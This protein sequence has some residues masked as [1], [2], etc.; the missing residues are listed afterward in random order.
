MDLHLAGRSALV[1]GASKGIGLAIT[2]ALAAEG[3]SVTA[4]ALK[5]SPELDEL[6]T[7]ADVTSVRV[8]LTHPA[9]PDEL[10]AAAAAERGGIDILVNNVGAVRPR[11]DGF[12]ALTDATIDVQQDPARM[13]PSD[14][15]ILWADDRKF[16]S[17]SGWQPLIPFEQTLRDTLDYWRGR[18]ALLK[19]SGSSRFRTEDRTIEGR[20]QRAEGSGQK[21]VGR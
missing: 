9:G 21:A 17:I 10:V 11:L 4:G 20:G 3:A 15:K 7:S 18:A 12:L 1:T 14:V 19:R 5:G 16:R 2:R 13:R 6:T 8:D